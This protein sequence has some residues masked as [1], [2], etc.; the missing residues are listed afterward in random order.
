MA[1]IVRNYDAAQTLI[2]SGAISKEAAEKL[3]KSAQ[4]DKA[5]ALIKGHEVAKPA[6]FVT[7][8]ALTAQGMP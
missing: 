8:A 3:N 6:R 4:D 1:L 2:D 7:M 5:K